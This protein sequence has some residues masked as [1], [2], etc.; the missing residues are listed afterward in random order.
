MMDGM[1]GLI[2]FDTAYPSSYTES[3][4]VPFDLGLQGTP[5]GLFEKPEGQWRRALHSICPNVPDQT[6]WR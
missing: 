5:G 3:L 1:M 4:A 6:Y 2:N